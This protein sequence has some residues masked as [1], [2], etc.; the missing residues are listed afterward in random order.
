MV[1]V[2]AE[3]AP[4]QSGCGTKGPFPFAEDDFNFDLCLAGWN[5]AFFCEDQEADVESSYG[6]AYVL[7]PPETGGCILLSLF[8]YDTST[9]RLMARPKGAQ[10]LVPPAMNT[11]HMG[12]EPK[13]VPSNKPG[14]PKVWPA[15]EGSSSRQRKLFNPA[16]GSQTASLFSDSLQFAW[17]EQ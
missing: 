7:D 6:G 12:D 14:V 3:W 10:P 9:M 5:T 8:A 2:S 16:K 1:I 17:V 13:W 11:T 15:S 4:N